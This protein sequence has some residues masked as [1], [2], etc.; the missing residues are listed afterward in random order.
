VHRVGE[1]PIERQFSV[2]AAGFAAGDFSGG[3]GGYVGRN[4][5]KFAE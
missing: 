1:N 4:G 3:A 2:G 5:E